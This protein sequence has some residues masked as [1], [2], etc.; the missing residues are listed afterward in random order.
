MKGAVLLG[1]LLT[2]AITATPS[3]TFAQGMPQ[4]DRAAPASA[5]MQPGAA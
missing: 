5:T 2:G 4:P 3:P 1:A